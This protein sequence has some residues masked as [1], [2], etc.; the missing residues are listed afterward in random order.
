MY[1]SYA[2]PHR[3]LGTDDI[4]GAQDVYGA[5]SQV[6]EEPQVPSP[7]ATE[8]TTSGTDSDGDGLSDSGETLITGTDPND[9]DS[10]NDGLEDGVEVA[11][12]MNPLDSDMDN[13]GADDGDEVAA[14]TNPLMPDQS[15]DISPELADEIRDFLTNAIKLQIK[16][17]RN[18]DASLTASVFGPDIYAILERNINQLKE[19]GLVQISE[20][21]Y[22]KSYLHDIRVRSNTHIEVD[23]C[24]VWTTQTYRLANSQLAAEDG[25]TLLPQTITLERLQGGWF[26]TN[27]EF[28]N[29]PAFCRE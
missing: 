3:F 2:G 7:G 28:A 21:D 25:P 29:A 5:R 13:D 20:I 16:A 22:Y 9:A 4:A 19:D 15:N 17:Y 1:P 8:P 27:V 12:R 23:T 26:I 18:N 6:P 11:N 24:E 10:D 14:G